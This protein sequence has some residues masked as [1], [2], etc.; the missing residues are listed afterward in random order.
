MSI[1]E[2]LRVYRYSSPDPQTIAIYDFQWKMPDGEQHGCRCKVAMVTR[3]LSHN[4]NDET[5]VFR[6]ILPFGTIALRCIGDDHELRA[7]YRLG[8]GRNGDNSF[9][10]PVI[11]GDALEPTG[12]NPT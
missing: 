11:D 1:V 5:D 3:Q 7:E 6:K 10:L 9:V 12:L 4:A 2:S 8:D